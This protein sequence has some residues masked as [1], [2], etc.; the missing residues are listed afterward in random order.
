MSDSSSASHPRTDEDGPLRSPPPEPPSDAHAQLA[1]PAFLPTLSDD[2]LEAIGYLLADPLA[3]HLAVALSSCSRGLR[4]ALEAPLRELKERR[5]NVEELCAKVG[6]SCDRLRG[7]TDVSWGNRDLTA[8]DMETLGML[9]ATSGLPQLRTFELGYNPLGDA[10]VQSLFGGL[11]RRALPELHHLLLYN[12]SFPGNV[13]G[14]AGAAALAAALSRGAMP[15]LQFLALSNNRV[16]DEGLVALAPPLRK[17]PE[18]TPHTYPPHT[19]P[20]ASLATRPDDGCEIGH[21]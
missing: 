21:L 14:N 11:G 2:E 5:Q 20:G 15:A 18:L 12:N 19:R 17:L 16:G 10:G 7:A 9:L 13:L 3:P 6:T 8:A 1:G 4:R